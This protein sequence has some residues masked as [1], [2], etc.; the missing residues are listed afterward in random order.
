MNRRHFIGLL[1]GAASALP[2]V[3]RA[4]QAMPVIGFIGPESHDRGTPRFQAFHQGLRETGYAEGRNVTV[5]YRWADG[6]PERFPA[7]AADL[8]GRQVN[9]IASLAGIP[10]ARAVK[11]ATATIPVVFQTGGD[12]VEIGLVASLSRPGG[13]LTGI[14]TLNVELG[15]KRLELLHELLPKATVIALL[16]NPTNPTAAPQA[17]ELQAA[18]HGFGMQIHVLN[19]TS[20]RDFDAVFARVASLPAPPS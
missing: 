14:S 9:A 3:A 4:Q 19:A 8:V 6:H 17:R 10:A 13:N 16:V 20:E 2:R 12:P 5:E 11:A 18:A 1:G 15:P 7:L